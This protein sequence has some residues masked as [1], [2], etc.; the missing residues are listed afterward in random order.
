[1][2]YHDVRDS[3]G[4]WAPA[5]S[6]N[7]GGA[8]FGGQSQAAPNGGGAS[9]APEH[10]WGTTMAAL[11]KHATSSPSSGSSSGGGGNPGKIE[12]P[13]GDAASQISA[14]QGNQEGF[15]EAINKLGR[16]LR[17]SNGNG[18][19][20]SNGQGE[21]PSPSPQPQGPA[22]EPPHDLDPHVNAYRAAGYGDREYAANPDISARI[23]TPM[24]GPVR[25]GPNHMPRPAT[26][27]SSSAVQH[28]SFGT[29]NGVG[30]FEA[31]GTPAQRGSSEGFGGNEANAG[32][33]RFGGVDNVG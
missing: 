29:G 11:T 8:S 1:M 26:Y 22:P 28:P 5:S 30:G 27:A 17:Q 12:S 23:G 4:R 10:D 25:Y 3:A 2:A 18:G 21:P 13:V 6:A 33:A 16:N 20:G 7:A 32:G 15:G 14:V 24:P 19:Q 31:I 9:F